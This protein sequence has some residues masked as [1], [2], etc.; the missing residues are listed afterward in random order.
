MCHGTA[1]E[2]LIILICSI[3]ATK[4]M[5]RRSF[6]KKQILNKMACTGIKFQLF[7]ELLCNA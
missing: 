4:N 5:L 1:L 7:V 3:L 6:S 2:S